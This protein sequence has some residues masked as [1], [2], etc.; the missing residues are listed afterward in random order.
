MCHGA[1]FAAPDVTER[2]S[3]AERPRF[4]FGW[5]SVSFLACLLLPNRFF[6]IFRLVFSLLPFIFAVPKPME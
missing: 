1:L 3:K 2:M 4:S 5:V 6:S